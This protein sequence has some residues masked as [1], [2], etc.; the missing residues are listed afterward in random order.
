MINLVSQQLTEE[1]LKLYIEVLN[2]SL[3]RLP[4]NKIHLEIEKDTQPSNTPTRTILISIR[5][6]VKKKLDQLVDHGVLA[7]VD[8]ATDRVLAVVT[9]KKKEEF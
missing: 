5:E 8:C 7:K 4:G 9:V 6:M 3:G 1:I 2:G